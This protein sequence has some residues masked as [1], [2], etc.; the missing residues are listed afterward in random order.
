[1]SSDSNYSAKTLRL[2]LGDQLNAGH[3]WFKAVNPEVLYVLM[4][5]RQ[6][7]E[8]VK[9]HI[10][11]I[12]GFFAAMRNFAYQLERRGHRVIYIKLDDEQNLQNF[13]GN[14]SYLIAVHKITH[15]EYQLPD[16]FRLDQLLKS[17]C[18]DLK[19]TSNYADSEHFLTS[20]E[21]LANFFGE[22]KSYLMETFYRHMRTSHAILM[23]SGKP[24]GGKWNYDAENRSRYDGKIPLKKHLAFDHDLSKLKTM[25]DLAGI[26]YFGK[27][28]AAHFEWPLSAK[29][30]QSLL[31]YFCA[32]LLPFFGT[33]EDAMLQEHISLFHSRLSFAL[34]VKMIGPMHVVKG[35]LAAWEQRK[36]SIGLQQVEGFIRQVIGWRE[37]MRGVYWAKMPEFAG[38]NFFNHQRKLPGWFW[39]GETKMNCLSKC[40]GQ[41]LNHAWAHHIQ[42][43]MVIGNFAL[44]IQ[45]DPDEVDAWYLGVYI[46]AIEWVEITNTRGMSQYAD[47]G[48]I[49]SKPYISSAAYI[50]RM[51]DYCKNCYYD[52]AKKHGE[53]SCPYNSFYWNFIA[54]NEDKLSKNPRMSMMYR[55]FERQDK[56]E[57]ASVLQQAGYYLENLENL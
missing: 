11:K 5:I 35:V 56:D 10:Q 29:E 53:R 43:L 33:Y 49:G 22:R 15:F 24:A 4:E 48:I 46:D 28:D 39:T 57:R 44:L 3:S 13:A 14:L 55:N 37:F 18:A 30:A 31:D 7:Q 21:E 50:N 1:M 2:V 25:I 17:F 45:A 9:H 20:R 27:A 23:D 47:G 41:S 34:N 42:R 19:I 40:I 51:S 36:E 6:E 16:E 54:A 12:L 38:L 32:E 52:P 8:Y 26:E